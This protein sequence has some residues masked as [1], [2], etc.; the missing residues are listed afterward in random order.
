MTNK[1]ITALVLLA[2]IPA[3][4]AQVCFTP[5]DHVNAYYHVNAQHT[6][7]AIADVTGDG[8]DDLITADYQADGVSVMPWTSNDVTGKPLFDIPRFTPAGDGALKLC[9]GR[10]NIDSHMDIAVVNSLTNTITVMLNDGG[11]YFT[12][13][14]YTVGNNPSGLTAGDFN[15]DGHLDLAVTSFDDNRVDFLKGTAGGSFTLVS[16]S[17]IPTTNYGSPVDVIAGDFDSDGFLDLAL[18]QYYA[19]DGYYCFVKGDGNF[20]FQPLTATYVLTHSPGVSVNDALM[21]RMDTADFNQDGRL[22]VV[23]NFV[24]ATNNTALIRSQVNGFPQSLTYA[25]FNTSLRPADLACADYNGDGH[26]DVAVVFPFASSSNKDSIKIVLGKGDG[27]FGAVKTFACGYRSYA[28]SIA[29]G[30]FNQDG[31]PDLAT[32]NYLL[33]NGST[34][35]DQ[36]SLVNITPSVTITG[37][38]TVCGPQSVMLT[39]SGSSALIYTWTSSAGSATGP[40]YAFNATTF[41]TPFSVTADS[42]GGCSNTIYGNVR[43]ITVNIGVGQ[44]GGIFTAYATNVAYQWL[45][46]D[47]AGDTVIP[48]ETGQSFTPLLSGSYAVEIIQ[49]GCMDTS[50]CYTVEVS[51]AGMETAGETDGLRIYPNPNDGRFFV[52]A[53]G[54]VPVQNIVVRNLLGQV[55]EI[56]PVNGVGRITITLNQPPGVYLIGRQDQDGRFEKIIVH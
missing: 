48:G 9:L 15:G 10:F 28:L 33:P 5:S 25:P 21:A 34:I 32:G 39:A 13:D 56:I 12:T 43:V 42:I 16:G 52:E 23:I 53:T 8:H 3:V 40:S 55:V 38:M 4:K 46:C 30:D 24:S 54:N 20:G 49:D 22:D 47:L 14:T 17:S 35:F 45:G 26:T 6:D 51:L 36:Y 41:N 27:S 7:I 31:K 1:F 2:A 19:N 50:D 29:T 18:A 37:D 11:G 44:S